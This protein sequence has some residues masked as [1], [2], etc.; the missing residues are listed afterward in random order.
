[1]VGVGFG[2]GLEFGEVFD[3][4]EEASGSVEGSGEHGYIRG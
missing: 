4:D 2:G 1:M 3:L